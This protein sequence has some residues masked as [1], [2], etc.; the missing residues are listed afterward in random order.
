[1][2][3]KISHAHFQNEH[4]EYKDIQNEAKQTHG[5]LPS[6]RSKK[7]YKSE[8]LSFVFEKQL[9][10]ELLSQPGTEYLRVY[11]GALP[12]NLAKAGEQ[13]RP[14]LILGAAVGNSYFDVGTFYVEWPE[15]IDEYGNPLP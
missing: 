10:L 15:G 3:K 12:K 6:D 14:T 8:E 4:Q 1:M 5:Q 13:G 11:Y 2:A 9:V 7:Y